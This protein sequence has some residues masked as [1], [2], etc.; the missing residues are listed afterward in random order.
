MD[1]FFVVLDNPV[2][3]YFPGQTLT[4]KVIV[5]IEKPTPLNGF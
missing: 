2:G 5:K 4:G 3:V 1:R